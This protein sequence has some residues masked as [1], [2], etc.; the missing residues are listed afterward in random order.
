MTQKLQV[1]PDK[2][3]KILVY[4]LETAPSTGYFWRGKW[5]V[6]ILR[7]ITE[8]R[9][10]CAAWKWLG[11]K[12]THVMRRGVKDNYE[13]VK[14]LRTLMDE[15]D[16]TVAHNGGNF[17][18]KVTYTDLILHG[19]TPPTPHKCVDTL[20]VAKKYFKFNSNS[21]DDLAK[22]LGIDGKIPTGGFQLWIDCQDNKPEAWKK[23]MEYNKNDVVVLEKVF[24]RLRPYMTN[25]PK[26]KEKK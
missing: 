16:I 10:I 20:K 12:D 1:I 9:I 6:D 15:A 23:M 3:L 22:R 5:E 13:L 2:D 19:F 21:L 7:Y 24:N 17:D 26:I 18:E 11:E 4:D 8:G 25:F 14:K